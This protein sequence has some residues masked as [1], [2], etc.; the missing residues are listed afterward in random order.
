MKSRVGYGGLRGAMRAGFTLVEM[1]VVVAIIGILAALTLRVTGYVNRQVG[2]KRTV[3]KLEQLRNAL[4]EYYSTYGMYPPVSGVS[5]EFYY[6]DPQAEP[7]SRGYYEGLSTYLF[8][9]D[10][11]ERWSKYTEGLLATDLISRSNSVDQFGWVRW[12]N[13][14]WT[15]PDAWDRAFRYV[16]T[17]PDYQAYRLWSAGS[18]G[19]DGSADDIG[20]KWSE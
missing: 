19:S 11:R 7:S 12:T 3:Q 9:D 18:D 14:Y 10:E 17:E 16:P 13:R 20:D 6:S 5:R 1:L 2:S 4:A 8:E 15:I